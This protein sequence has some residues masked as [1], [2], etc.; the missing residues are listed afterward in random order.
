VLYLTAHYVRSPSGDRFG[1]NGAVYRNEGVAPPTSLASEGVS[2]GADL[3][4]TVATVTNVPPGGNRVEA[5]LDV[6]APD[7]CKAAEIQRAL[8]DFACGIPEDLGDTPRWSGTRSSEN[9]A[10]RYY[11]TLRAPSPP[12]R[13]FDALQEVALAL[14]S[15]GHEANPPPLL[16]EWT[17]GTGKRTFRLADQCL[18]V[19]EAERPDLVFAPVTIRDEVYE[20][21]ASLRTP[22]EEEVPALLLI[23]LGLADHFGDIVFRELSGG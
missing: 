6:V 18:L 23:D 13:S 1:I 14:H 21:Y 12:R 4:P 9:I 20:A 10:V 7:G 5:Y 3:G 11:W 15:R 19:V 2:I 22:F 8:Q 16:I 17:H